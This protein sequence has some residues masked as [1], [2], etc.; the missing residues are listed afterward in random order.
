MSP[1]SSYQTAACSA[2]PSALMVATTAYRGASRKRR[3]SAERVEES[4]RGAG[5]HRHVVLSWWL[6]G[7]LGGAPEPTGSMVPAETHFGET[8][9]ARVLPLETARGAMAPSSRDAR[10]YERPLAPVRIRRGWTGTMADR[11]SRKPCRSRPLAPGGRAG[12]DGSRSP[13]PR[14]WP[15]CVG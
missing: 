6:I 4:G 8:R 5:L 7:E 12:L 3:P 9:P 1:R 13:R 2:L 10:D 15:R 11:P 14:P